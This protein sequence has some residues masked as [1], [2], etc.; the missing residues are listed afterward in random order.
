MGVMPNREARIEPSSNPFSWQWLQCC[1][2]SCIGIWKEGAGIA[3]KGRRDTPYSGEFR[4][5]ET[6]R[7]SQS[8]QIQARTLFPLSPSAGHFLGPNFC[9]P[10]Q[11]QVIFHCSG[12]QKNASIEIRLNI[13]S[14]NMNMVTP[15]I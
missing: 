1:Q 10:Q 3:G 11:F 8:H 14:L 5:P 7:E 2:E 4:N 9:T 15:E 6:R 13:K 12:N